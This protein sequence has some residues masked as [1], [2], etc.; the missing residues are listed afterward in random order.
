MSEIKPK[1]CK[2]CGKVFI[3]ETYRHRMCSYECRAIAHKIAM[4]KMYKKQLE[5]KR[6]EAKAQLKPKECPTCGKEFIPRNGRQVCCDAVCQKIRNNQSIKSW[7]QEYK[8]E[9]QTGVKKEK[10]K[11]KPKPISLAEFNAQARAMGM[12]YG[13]YDL[14]LRRKEQKKN[15]I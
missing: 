13:E 5:K 11:E 9:M 10:K 12:S 1:K 6:A 8:Q 7:Y 2:M 3:P 14:Y 15:V 4:D